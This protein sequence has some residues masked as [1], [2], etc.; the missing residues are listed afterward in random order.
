M[1]R[2]SFVLYKTAILFVTFVSTIFICSLHVKFS[3]MITPRNFVCDTC[4]MYVPFKVM[5]TVGLCCF[6]CA[7]MIKL[8]LFTLSDNLL[9]LNHISSFSSA[10]LTVHA[11]S[12]IFLV[13]YKMLVSSADKIILSNFDTSHMSFMYK[14]NSTG[15]RIDPCGTPHLIFFSSELLLL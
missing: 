2:T 9:T 15:P 13:E 1:S 14:I 7:N 6:L 5:F 3:S 11:I 8:V 10:L 4:S 12:P